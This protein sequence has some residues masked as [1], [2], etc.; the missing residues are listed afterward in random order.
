MMKLFALSLLLGLSGCGGLSAPQEEDDSRSIPCGPVEGQ[1]TQSCLL[2]VRDDK[3]KLILT[4]RQPDGGFRRLIWPK[5]G[6]LAAADGA[7]PL[8]ATGLA[9]GGVEARIGGWLYRIE[10]KGGGLP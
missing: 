4:L 10:A 6:Q 2:Q 8:K 9:G 1:P 7:E 5:G 3:G